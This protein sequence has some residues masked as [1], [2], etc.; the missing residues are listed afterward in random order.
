MLHLDTTL[1]S[2][3]TLLIPTPRSFPP[4]HCLGYLDLLHALVGNSS[5]GKQAGGDIARV[6]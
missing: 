3:L 4:S 2:I 5:N 1:S 6:L